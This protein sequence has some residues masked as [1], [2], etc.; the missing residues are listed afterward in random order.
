MATIRDICTEA[1]LEIGYLAGNETLN[2]TDS[3]YAVKKLQRL[4]NLWNAKRRA[5]YAT[6]LS[7]YTTTANLSPHTIGPSAATWSTAIS[8]RS[9]RCASSS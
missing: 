1:A 6:L 8:S 4:L 7:Q 9:G 5:V 3:E 2:T